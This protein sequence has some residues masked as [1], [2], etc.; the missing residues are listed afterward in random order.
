MEKLATLKIVRYGKLPFKVSFINQGNL[1]CLL[2]NFLRIFSPNGY[3]L[4]TY[5]VDLSESLFSVEN[6]KKLLFYHHDIAKIANSNDMT[7]SALNKNLNTLA[8]ILKKKN[9]RLY[10]MPAVDKYDL[11]S[12]YIVNNRYPK[13]IFF[14]KLR[15]LPKKYT[16]ID[17]KRILAREVSKGEKDIFYAD[18]THWSWKASKRIFEEVRFK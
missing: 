4:R 9:I 2:Y 11:Y 5:L 14:E 7:I 3:F 10:F 12:D 8:E 17:S 15:L 1:D 13:S 18:D 6:D 16:F